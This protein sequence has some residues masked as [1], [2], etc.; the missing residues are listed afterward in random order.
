MFLCFRY[1]FNI[2]K[3][4]ITAWRYCLLIVPPYLLSICDQYLSFSAIVRLAVITIYFFYFVI[5]IIKLSIRLSRLLLIISKSRLGYYYWEVSGTPIEYER[6]AK[7]HQWIP[8]CGGS[9]TCFR[10]KAPSGPHTFI[11]TE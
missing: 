5:Y 10:T 11:A 3:L 9:R 6:K 4:S 8:G 2:S 1:N 7:V